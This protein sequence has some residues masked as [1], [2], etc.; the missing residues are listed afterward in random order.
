MKKLN[1]LVHKHSAK[2]NKP[3]V[4]RDKKK[5]YQRRGKHPPRPDASSES[6]HR[7]IFLL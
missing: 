1:N 6:V 3:K 5:D 4:F 2:I 7:P